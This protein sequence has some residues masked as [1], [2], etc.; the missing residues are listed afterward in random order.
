MLAKLRL[1]RKLLN[2]RVHQELVDGACVVQVKDGGYFLRTPK[3][4]GYAL[5]EKWWTQVEEFGFVSAPAGIKGYVFA[6]G[7]CYEPLLGG[8]HGG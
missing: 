1:R 5:L 2:A 8:P 3:Y 6:D 7:A 4:A